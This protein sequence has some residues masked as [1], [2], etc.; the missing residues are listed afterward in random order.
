MSFREAQSAALDS[1]ARARKQRV[2]EDVMGMIGLFAGL[3]L[4]CVLL[5][6][7]A[8]YALPVFVG[9][10]VGWWTL[11]HGAG[12]GCVIAG[13]LAGAV[14]LYLGRSAVRSDHRPVRWIVLTVFAAPAVYTGFTI[15]DDLASFIQTPWRILFALIAAVAIGGTTL[16][17]LASASPGSDWRGEA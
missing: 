4:F 10:S 5:W 17:R 14:A 8:I 13:L 12:A 1:T 15:V 6:Y 9:F 3:G 2:M 7:C 11:N 16:G